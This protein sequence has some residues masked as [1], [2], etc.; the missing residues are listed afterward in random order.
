MS[1]EIDADTVR[2]ERASRFWEPGAADTEGRSDPDTGGAEL[3]SRFWE[4]GDD[5][6][7]TVGHSQPDKLAIL[8]EI[9]QLL[10]STLSLNTLYEMIYQQVARVLTV[11]LQRAR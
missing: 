3:A 6:P 10:C 7:S 5:D 2:A 11:W 9:G 4:P 8:N 1:H